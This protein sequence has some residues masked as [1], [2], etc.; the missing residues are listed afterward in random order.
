MLKKAHHR[1]Q[2][3]WPVRF[4]TVKVASLQHGL[5]GREKLGQQ[6]VDGRNPANQLIWYVYIYIYIRIIYPI[7]YRVLYIPGGAINSI[8]VIV[9][10]SF[11]QGRSLPPDMVRFVLDFHK[12]YQQ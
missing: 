7:L 6:T 3:A 8:F 9:T 1:K 10:S 11:F 2:K 5:V 12:I 4:S